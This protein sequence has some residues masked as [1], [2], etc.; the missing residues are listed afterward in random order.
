V[1]S[2]PVPPIAMPVWAASGA[3][4]TLCRGLSA[5]GDVEVVDFAPPLLGQGRSRTCP[6]QRRDRS[7]HQPKCPGEAD[8]GCWTTG[9][10][11]GDGPVEEVMQDSLLL[12]RQ[13]C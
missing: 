10:A 6:G 8:H 13:A 5:A 2:D 11:V 1:R 4:G 9:S 3:H 7:G 12:V